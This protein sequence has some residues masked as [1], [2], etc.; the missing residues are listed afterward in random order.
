MD[1]HDVLLVL[2]IVGVGTWLGANVIQAVIPPVAARSGSETLGW[3]YRTSSMLS[4]RLYM[5]AAILILVTGVLLVLQR[6]AYGFGTPFVT[7]GFAMIVVGAVLGMV[8][9]GPG[10]REAATAAE[11]GDRPGLQ[12]AAGR[13]TRFGIVDTIL[14]LFTI[15]AMV[16]RLGV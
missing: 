16:L 8:V 6:E 12:R 10:G 2:H 13:L 3:W 7:I 4:S 1:F 5:P 11:T 15:T 14:L 9:F